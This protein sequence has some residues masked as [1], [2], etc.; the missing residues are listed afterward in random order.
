MYVYYINIYN[1][2]II[3]II[4]IY[5]ILHYIYIYMCVNDFGVHF[6]LVLVASAFLLL[7]LS[8]PASGWFNL[9]S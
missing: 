4:Y 9:H 8:N 3:Y 2:Y 1:L 5:I 6:K 7:T